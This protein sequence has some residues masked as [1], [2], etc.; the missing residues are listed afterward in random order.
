MLPFSISIPREQRDPALFTA[1]QRELPGI[2]AWAVRGCEKWQK[3]GL[4]PPA[5]VRDATKHYRREVDHVQR[6]LRECTESSNSGVVHTKILYE[7]YEN[8][9]ADNGEHAISKT[10]IGKR[11]IEAK[12]VP[13]RHTGNRAWC[14]LT[15]RE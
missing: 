14:G 8:W 10:A 4:N 13:T 3:R 7:R 11:L 12:Y 6:F 15:L 5:A 9:C 1:L 2:F